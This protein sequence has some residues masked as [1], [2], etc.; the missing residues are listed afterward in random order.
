M[1]ARHQVADKRQH[2]GDNK[3]Y[4]E[5]SGPTYLLPKSLSPPESFL[6]GEL[7]GF[8]EAGYALVTWPGMR[9]AMPQVTQTTIP[10]GQHD[11]GR[12]VLLALVTI[13]D[14]LTPMIAG[15]VQKPNPLPPTA[16]SPAQGWDV[17]QDDKRLILTAQEEITLCCGQASLTLTKAGKVLLQGAYV[18]S[19]SSGV[20]RIKGGSVQIN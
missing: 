10:L 4:D 14:R 3:Q 16:S 6:V 13:E 18:L 7:V 1:S 5:L 19:R 8:D 15:L 11:L 2:T 17:R 12:Q 20:N 9:E